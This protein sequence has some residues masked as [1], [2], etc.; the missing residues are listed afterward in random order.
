MPVVTKLELL[1][2]CFEK[3]SSVSSFLFF[4]SCILNCKIAQVLLLHLMSKIIYLSSYSGEG[5]AVIKT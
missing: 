5:L 1:K 3:V 2:T 4:N